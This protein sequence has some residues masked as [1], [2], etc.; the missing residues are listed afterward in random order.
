MLKG[1]LTMSAKELER[2][3]MGKKII[4][5]RLTQVLG[6]QQLGLTSR[7][8][9]RLVKKYKKYGAEGLVSKQRGKISNNK[10]SDKKIEDIKKLVS[11]HYYDFGPKFAAEKLSEKHGIQ[12]S[13]ET[14]RQWMVDWGQ[15]KWV[16]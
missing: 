9:K 6:A 11:M 1:L 5:K 8:V 13:K 12:V 16:N 10:F 2:V 14:L 15:Q 7:Q 4:D 3:S